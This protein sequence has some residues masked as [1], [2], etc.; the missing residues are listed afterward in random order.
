MYKLFLCLR[1]LRSRLLAYLAV[2]AVMLCVFL[3]LLVTC[4]MNGFLEKIERAAKGL[5]GDIVV[6][7]AGQ[8]GMAN[9]EEFI[10]LCQSDPRVKEDIE[11]ASPFILSYGVLQVPGQPHYREQVMVAGIVLPPGDT[12]SKLP[13]RTA[14][15]DFEQGLFVQQGWPA[16][17][18]EAKAD[19][20][21][22]P[23]VS[24]DP[25]VENMLSAI[26][27]EYARTR[28][29]YAAEVLD[30]FAE[31]VRQTGQPAAGQPGTVSEADVL[32]LLQQEFQSTADI[33]AKTSSLARVDE[34]VP[35]RLHASYARLQTAMMFQR[36]AHDWIVNRDR[37]AQQLTEARNQLNRA[38]TE[39]AE[40][41]EIV[42]WEQTV[43]DLS[44]KVFEGP[45]NRVILGLGI[46]GLSFYTDD[47][48]LV[49]YMVPGQKVV[50]FVFPLGGDTNLTQITPNVQAFSVVD[51]SRTDVYTIDTKF[52][53]VPFDLLQGLNNMDRPKRCSAIHIKVTPGQ[54]DEKSLQA[55]T[56]ELKNVWADYVDRHPEIPPE[57][58]A[59]MIQTWRERQA[60]TIGP[61]E[62][63]RTMAV[64]IM[65]AMWIVVIT[66][67]LVIFYI[68][69]VQKTK[70]IGVLKS[71]GAS[72]W[73]VAA[74]FLGWGL[75]VGLIGSILGTILGT[76][77]VR[78]IN[79]IEQWIADVSGYKFYDR[80]FYLFDQI[81]N[82]V[83]WSSAA[84]IV[85]ASMLAG[86][87]GALIPAMRAARMQPVEALRYE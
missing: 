5:F 12:A 56:G 18:A 50:L 61:I 71:L 60:K 3:L 48:K 29:I 37:Y 28:D 40:E 82:E 32:N 44:N 14:V 7:P 20:S 10:E 58:R 83:D 86:L 79:P 63:Q 30:P 77:V 80:E 11:S 73:G 78:N 57:D 42:A 87:V 35:V 67:I 31:R 62:K 45:Q 55:I 23:P 43:A 85:G 54:D 46:Q 59:L 13:P 24:F 76:I 66:L 4:V 52:V 51:D 41:D 84:W 27:A 22:H 70:D 49:R 68:M 16:T 25:P 64:V 69:V 1:Y 33:T 47:D 34:M 17:E 39:G 15:S 26:R 36:D 74:I 65:S 38:L 9:Y 19:G 2:I 81:P 75:A 21:E 72:S 53:Y 8:R 6:E